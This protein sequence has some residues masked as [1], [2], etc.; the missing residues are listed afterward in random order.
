[1]TRV[2]WRQQNFA[3]RANDSTSPYSV[4]VRDLEYVC[5]VHRQRL[6]CVDLVTLPSGG[7]KVVAS[8]SLSFL[9]ANIFGRS[10]SALF[11]NALILCSYSFLLYFL[12]FFSRQ[13]SPRTHHT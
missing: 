11:F 9:V 12:A 5:H 2:K 7:M 6:S 13:R 10:L 1:M 4:H 3:E 8:A